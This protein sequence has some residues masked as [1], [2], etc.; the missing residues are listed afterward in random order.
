MRVRE[1]TR[2]ATS[3]DRTM[4]TGALLQWVEQQRRAADSAV[5][6]RLLIAGDPLAV[7]RW[8]YWEALAR[9]GRL[10]RAHSRKEAERPTRTQTGPSAREPNGVGAGSSSVAKPAA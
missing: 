6:E 5:L 7:R 8:A 4:E 3:T 1:R 2:A 9:A 10:G